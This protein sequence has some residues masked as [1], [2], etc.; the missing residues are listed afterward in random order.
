MPPMPP[1]GMPAPAFSGL[2]EIRASVVRIMPAIETAFSI[3]ERVTL[4][5][6]MMP[7]LSMST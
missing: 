1:G 6:S 4:A 3:A 5:G 7:A 2:S